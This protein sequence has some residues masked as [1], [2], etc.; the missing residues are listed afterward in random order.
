MSTDNDDES[1]KYFVSEV[2]SP[3]SSVAFAAFLFRTAVTQSDQ[4][5]LL[6]RRRKMM[7]IPMT[8]SLM[9]SMLMVCQIS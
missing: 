5:H 3:E 1:L 4:K 2:S 6:Q 7:G 9:Y 8:V